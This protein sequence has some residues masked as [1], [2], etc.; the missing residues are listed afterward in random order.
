MNK[1]T[2][3]NTRANI[4][5]I[6]LAGLLTGCDDGSKL[7]QTYHGQGMSIRNEAAMNPSTEYSFTPT[8]VGTGTGSA[9]FKISGTSRQSNPF[10]KLKLS[11]AVMEMSDGRKIRCDC[12]DII[13]SGDVN[14]RNGETKFDDV[15]ID[16]KNP[17]LHIG[18]V[19]KS[20]AK[21]PTLNFKITIPA[22][23]PIIRAQPDNPKYKYGTSFEKESVDLK[24]AFNA[25]RGEVGGNNWIRGIYSAY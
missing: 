17:G 4:I 12:E 15:E 3:L 6:A 1:N 23:M 19:P 10:V 20:M 11:Q 21:K 22:I 16:F 18:E 14:P 13:L 8:F 25:S 5:I 9:K 7:I 2:F 24:F